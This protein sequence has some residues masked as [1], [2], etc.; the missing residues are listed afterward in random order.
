M[1]AATSGMPL[2]PPFLEGPPPISDREPVVD[3]GHEDLARQLGQR[4]YGPTGTNGWR[5]AAP[6]SVDRTRTEYERSMAGSSVSEPSATGYPLPN[7]S[8][9]R[10]RRIE[11]MPDFIACPE[12]GAPF[13][14]GARSCPSCGTSFDRF[15]SKRAIWDL[16]RSS[17]IRGRLFLLAV[18]AVFAITMVAHLEG[19]V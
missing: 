1:S 10:Y 2:A 11:L 15:R 18:L 12:C 16:Y 8:V 6:G 5:T 3:A 17:S 7:R 13:E 4:T 19:L 14:L 9:P